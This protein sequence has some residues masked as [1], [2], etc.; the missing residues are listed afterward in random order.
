MNFPNISP[1]H[2]YWNYWKP[3][4]NGT[5]EPDEWQSALM[6]LVDEA[7]NQ[8]VFYS[9]DMHDWVKNHADFI[10][11]EWWSYQYSGT[12]VEGGIMGMEVYSARKALEEKKK[13]EAN[14]K[15]LENIAIS[16]IMGVMSVNGKRVNKCAVKSIDGGMVTFTGVTGRYDCE[17]RTEARNISNMIANAVNRGWRK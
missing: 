13:M 12:K 6:N 1:K 10:P 2:D 14:K 17:F 4:Q 5:T 8:G 7:L 3:V 11:L 16:Q 15:A 9:D